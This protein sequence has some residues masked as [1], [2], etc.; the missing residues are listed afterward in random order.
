MVLGG[1]PYALV[2]IFNIFIVENYKSHPNDSSSALPYA[3]SITAF[4][5]VG[6]GAPLLWTG[7]GV[8]EGLALHH[9]LTSMLL[10]YFRFI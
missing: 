9:T 8:R 7:Q 2:V 4:F 1:A 5:L 10:P 6:V 3:L